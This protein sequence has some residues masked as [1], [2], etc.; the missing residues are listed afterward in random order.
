[1]CGDKK[2]IAQFYRDSSMINGYSSQCK[3]CRK[4]KSNRFYLLKFKY[5]ITETDYYAILAKQDGVCAICGASPEG[6]LHGA[7]SVDHCHN[8]S[9]VRGLICRDCNFGLG[10]FKDD[11][12]VLEYAAAYIR[13][14]R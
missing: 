8:S 5:G 3:T 6:E 7:L 11:P 10:K 12:D 9:K 4:L 14:H 2:L 1:M 13:E